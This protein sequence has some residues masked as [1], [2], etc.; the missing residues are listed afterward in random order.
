MVGTAG[1]SSNFLRCSLCDVGTISFAGA[2]ACNCTVCVCPA[3][4][5]DST[6]QT[7]EFCAKGK[8]QPFSGQ[9]DCQEFP[10]GDDE[11]IGRDE[12]CIKVCSSRRRLS[13]KFG[14]GYVN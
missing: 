12:S 2:S 1:S 8:F 7:C 3:G 14:P 9:S 10:C 4:S 11:L 13:N 6:G 5:Y